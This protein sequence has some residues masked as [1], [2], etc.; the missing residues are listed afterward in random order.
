MLVAQVMAGPPEA[1][2]N[3]QQQQQRAVGALVAKSRHDC[4][5]DSDLPSHPDLD[6]D[7]PTYEGSSISAA[8]SARRAAASPNNSEASWRSTGEDAPPRP[9]PERRKADAMTRSGAAGD[10]GHDPDLDSDSDLDLGGQETYNCQ[11]CAA[12]TLPGTA[13]DMLLA[14]LPLPSHPALPIIPSDNGG[15]VAA[16]SALSRSPG[17]LPRVFIYLGLPRERWPGIIMSATR[18]V[19][20]Y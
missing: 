12:T 5:A 17:L 8:L 16:A 13:V 18:Q 20:E 11:C 10:L 15:E 2:L 1:P 14:P 19:W 9:I 7:P 6:P 4:C 3:E